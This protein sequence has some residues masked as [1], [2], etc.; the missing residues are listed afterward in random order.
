MICNNLSLILMKP[1]IITFDSIKHKDKKVW[2]YIPIQAIFEFFCW[3]NHGTSCQPIK[4]F[5]VAISESI[6]FDCFFALSQSEVSSWREFLLSLT[7][8][9]WLIIKLTKTWLLLA[10]KL[11]LVRNKTCIEMWQEGQHTTQQELWSVSSLSSS[12]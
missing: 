12:K 6:V 9:W 7:S 11:K 8:K 3:E 1:I 2:K 10:Q 4:S 5:F